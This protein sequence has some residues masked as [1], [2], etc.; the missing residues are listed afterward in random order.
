ML[1]VE[2]GARNM[3]V[4]YYAV[5]QEREGPV[6]QDKI[7]KLI[8]GGVIGRDAYIWRKGMADWQVVADHPDFAAFFRVPT[9]VSAPPALP[10]THAPVTRAEPA[11][12]AAQLAYAPRLRPWPRIW[13]RM[14]DNMLLWPFLEVGSR[15]AMITFA[16]YADALQTLGYSALFGLAA[17]FASAVLL[18]T[19]MTLFGTT[20]GKALVGVLVP[21][22]AGGSAF[23]F[24]LAREFKVLFF[25][26]ALG[27]PLAFIVTFII[28]Y[29]RLASGRPA[30]YDE[31]KPPVIAN[32][33][34]LRLTVAIILVVI[35]FV[36]AVL[37]KAALR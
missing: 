24:Y 31:Y 21:V 12:G 18:A 34:K 19:S 36:F 23:S 35:V 26:Y 25:A 4:W 33:G 14:L 30:M 7:E 32:P 16:P 11:T 27:I 5:G 15:A 20:P 9:P 22:P 2:M 8:V 17:M 1:L 28:Q 6:D 29:L 10:P 37:V 13:A 3:T